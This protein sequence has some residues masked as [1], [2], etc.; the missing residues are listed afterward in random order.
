MKKFESK[1]VVEWIMKIRQISTEINRLNIDNNIKCVYL[2]KD[3]EIR[4]DYK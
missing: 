3:K 1:M 4:L 2:G